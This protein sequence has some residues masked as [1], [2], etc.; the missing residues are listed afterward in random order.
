M[1]SIVLL[2]ES[3]QPGQLSLP[4]ES[5]ADLPAAATG[6]TPGANSKSIPV[7]AA[8]VPATG[9]ASRPAGCRT[10]AAARPALP[11]AVEQHS[12]RSSQDTRQ[13]ALERALR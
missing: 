3:D 13:G 10:A 1:F 11:D 8:S 9:G 5:A 2:P 4:A 7:P 12:A 6:S